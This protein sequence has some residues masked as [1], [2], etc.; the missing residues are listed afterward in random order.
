MLCTM[1]ERVLYRKVRVM[2]RDRMIIYMEMRVIDKIKNPRFFS[3]NLRYDTKFAPPPR[4]A[5]P[6][7]IPLV[8]ARLDLESSLS[9]FRIK[10]TL[11]Q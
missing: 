1:E 2:Y 11:E 10:L 4:G 5:V 9:R 3:T 7:N 6:H 8:Q